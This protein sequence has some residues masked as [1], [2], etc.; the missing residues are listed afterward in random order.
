MI[1]INTPLRQNAT[2]NLAGGGVNQ[3]A[4]TDALVTVKAH[5]DGEDSTE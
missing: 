4:I 5:R 1:Y 3:R 2:S